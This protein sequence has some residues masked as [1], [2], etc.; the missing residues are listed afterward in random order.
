[1]T[2]PKASVSSIVPREAFGP[3]SA[4]SLSSVCGWRELKRTLWPARAQSLPTTPPILPEPTMPMF[5]IRASSCAWI[6]D[7]S[8]GF[9]NP[10]T[11]AREAESFNVIRDDSEAK[12]SGHDQTF[13]SKQ[14]GQSNPCQH[15]ARAL[16][17]Q[18][19]NFI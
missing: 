13:F 8:N 17:E 16:I 4:A 18:L 11:P 6:Q 14:P 10:V 7:A 15:G 19:T 12:Y 1:M 2:S 3:A 5:M 9:K